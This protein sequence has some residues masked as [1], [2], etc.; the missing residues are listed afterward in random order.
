[1]NAFEEC[2]S[3]ADKINVGN[4]TDARADVIKLLDQYRKNGWEYTPL[5]NHLI[6]CVGLYPYMQSDSSDWNDAFAANCFCA[7][8]G[9]TDLA[10]LHIEQSY[11]LKKLLIGENI[12]VSA[13]TS[14]GKSYIIDA[15]IAMKRPACIFIIVPTVALADETR[16]RL[17]RKFSNRYSIITTS[18]EELGEKNIFVFPQ[19]RAFSYI[20]KVSSID[21]LVIDEVYKAGLDDE[22]ASKLLSAMIELGKIAKQKYFLGPNIDSIEPNPFTQGLT[23]IREDDFKTVVT[24]AKHSYR[25]KPNT[26]SN[27]EFKKSELLKILNEEDSKVLVY[28]SSLKQVALVGNILSNHLAYKNTALCMSFSQWLTHNYGSDCPLVPLVQ[29]GVGLHNGTLH[30]SLAQ[31]QIKLFEEPTGL[32]TI[33]STSSIIEGV[34]TQAEKV[35]LWNNKISTKKLDYFTFRNIIGRAGR[36]L[37]YFIGYVYLLEEA[38]ERQEKQ[39]ELPLND[40]V[41]CGLEEDNP[42]IVL[43]LKQKNKLVSYNNE[44]QTL[45]GK[46]AYSN[47]MQSGVLKGTSPAMVLR[48]AKKIKADPS[49]PL[50]YEDLTHFNTYKWRKPIEDVFDVAYGKNVST[51]IKIGLWVFSS[52]WSKGIIDAMSKLQRYGRDVSDLF[53]LERDV[54]FKVPNV[55]SLV[56]AIK[57]TLYPWSPDI[58]PFIKSASNVFLPKNVFILEEYGLPRMLS[59]KIHTLGIINLEDESKPIQTVIQEFKSLGEHQIISKLSSQILDFDKYIIHYFYTG[60]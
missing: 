40:E 17:A 10:T 7:E 50:G 44:L 31:I 60:I 11:I 55:L 32:S 5:L 57:T 20:G 9:D 16:R 48:I 36:M 28:T 21:L 41:I 30:R 6:R 1:M 51:D 38:P 59:K 25:H 4:I 49:W 22:R 33:I 12:L 27:D 34:N 8:T 26:Q 56:Y 39:L 58:R 46:E 18:D 53:K 42:G 54:N 35:V 19:E 29:K 47:L 24:K 14:F 2:K 37:K 52:N 15:Y 43:N 13:P 23:F 3:I 45:L